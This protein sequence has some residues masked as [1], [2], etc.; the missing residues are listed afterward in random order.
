MSDRIW[1][2]LQGTDAIDASDALRVHVVNSHNVIINPR[3]VIN[4]VIPPDHRDVFIDDL[5]DEF[6]RSFT[7]DTS[8]IDT[9][10]ESKTIILS[11]SVKI[12][13]PSRFF[14][15]NVRVEEVDNEYLVKI[16]RQ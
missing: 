11:D 5:V 10:L 6:P 3:D 13:A 9:R 12:T 14:D 7:K 8:L 4:A 16:R 15:S 1:S 2:E